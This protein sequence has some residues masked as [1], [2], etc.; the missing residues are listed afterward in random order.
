[1][2]HVWRVNR[3]LLMALLLVI[4][5]A[6]ALACYLAWPWRSPTG[7][8]PVQPE[9]PGPG[10]EPEPSPGMEH[11]P[12]VGLQPPTAET[13]FAVAVGIGAS[14]LLGRAIRRRRTRRAD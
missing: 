2:F 4:V 6:I 12:T 13:V 5:V 11:E 14:Y 10:I 8:L 3:A 1:M 7:Y 9:V